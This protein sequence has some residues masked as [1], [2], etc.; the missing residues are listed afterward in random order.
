MFKQRNNSLEGKGFT[1]YSASLEVVQGGQAMQYH[2]ICWVSSKI[3]VGSM[4]G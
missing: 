2:P 4:K 1:S 3:Y